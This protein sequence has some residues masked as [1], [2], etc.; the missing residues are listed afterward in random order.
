[1][2]VIKL[3]FITDENKIKGE[4]IAHWL[5]NRLVTEIHEDENEKPYDNLILSK[6]AKD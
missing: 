1:M 6:C 4:I 5:Y 2:Q 3:H